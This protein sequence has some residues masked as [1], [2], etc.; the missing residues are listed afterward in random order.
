[1]PGLSVDGMDLRAVHETVGYAI[2]AARAGGGPTLVEAKTYRFCG[3]SKSDAGGAYRSREEVAA[4]QARDPLVTWRAELLA[5]GVAE[6]ELERLEAGVEAEIEAA[7]R[8]ALDS[9][10]AEDEATLGVYAEAP[11]GAVPPWAPFEDALPGQTDAAV[12]GAGR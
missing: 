5:D 7:T 12:V 11:E 9:P 2:A 1:M 3:H 8:F 4:W 6:A 10:Y